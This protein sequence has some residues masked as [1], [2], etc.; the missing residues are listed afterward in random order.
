MARAVEDG[1]SGYI[2]TDVDRL[3]G[4]MQRLL[5]DPAEARRL[6]EGARRRAQLRFGLPRF[7]DDWDAAWD[8]ATQLTNGTSPPAT[9][10]PAPN[11]LTSTTGAPA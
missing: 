4:C 8:E 9:E 7:L 3:V 1:V 11:A 6:G 5:A 10:A 2:D